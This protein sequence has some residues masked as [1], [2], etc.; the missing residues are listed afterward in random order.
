MVLG[1]DNGEI[2]SVHICLH[3]EFALSLNPLNS[4]I[5]L[6]LLHHATGLILATLLVDAWVKIIREAPVVIC[7][8][9]QIPAFALNAHFSTSKTS[10]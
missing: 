10:T 2:L 4:F 7:Q 6:S 5:C 1:N 3:Q 8:L 9:I